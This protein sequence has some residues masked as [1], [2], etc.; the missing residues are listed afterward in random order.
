LHV[1]V[2]A[3]VTCDMELEPAKEGKREKTYYKMIWIAG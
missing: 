1:E 2:E 3:K